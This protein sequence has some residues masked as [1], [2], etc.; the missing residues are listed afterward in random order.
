MGHLGSVFREL[1]TISGK[2][3]VTKEKEEL[4][5]YSYDATGI[6]H[7]PDMVVFPGSETEISKILQLASKEK[8]IIVPRGTGSGMTGGSVPVKGGLI[9][10]LTRMNKI[11]D[12]DEENFT[13]RVQ[14]F[15]FHCLMDI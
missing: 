14:S 2:P 7:L 15:F 3:Y 13:V 9:M 4:L 8:L 10:V 12:I 6:S 1:Q 5:C 11:I